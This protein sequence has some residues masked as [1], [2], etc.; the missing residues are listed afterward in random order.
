LTHSRWGAER[1][2][3]PRRG[4]WSQAEIARLRELYG[5]REERALARDLNR[6]V[7]S[8]RRMA[9]RLFTGAA[10]GGPWTAAEVLQIKKYIG[11]VERDELARILGR[12]PEDV[13]RKVADLARVQSTARWSQDE[14]SS[15]K[16]LYGGRTDEDLAIVF[17]RSVDTVRRLAERLRLAKDKAFL[18]KLAGAPATRMPRW[19]RHEIERLKQLYPVL[20]NLEIAKKLERS[21][22]SVV[23][24]AHYLKLKKEPER[25]REMGRENVGLRYRKG[26]G[27]PA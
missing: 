22:K 15:F 1:S 11:G 8:V 9:Q 20:P 2:S 6:S 17:G 16:R 4:R 3:G 19:S 12:S 7:E 13:E 18:R 23:S 26:E 27:P 25:L 24:K 5:L 14:V 10:H 21:V